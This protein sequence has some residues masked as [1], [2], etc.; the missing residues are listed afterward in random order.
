MPK[1]LQCFADED[2]LLCDAHLAADQGSCSEAGLQGPQ[3]AA[4][5]CLLPSLRAALVLAQRSASYPAAVQQAAEDV[6]EH[7]R[8]CQAPPSWPA[9][10][11]PVG[12]EL[13]TYKAYV[14][15]PLHDRQQLQLRQSRAAAAADC[16]QAHPPESFCPAV[17]E[18]GQAPGE[19]SLAAAAAYMLPRHERHSR[20]AAGQRLDWTWRPPAQGHALLAACMAGCKQ[21]RTRPKRGACNACKLQEATLAALAPSLSTHSDCKQGSRCARWT[22]AGEGD[23]VAAS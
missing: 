20:W 16:V 12:K 21:E 9:R 17:S 15:A 18:A 19:A 8:W 6:R 14:L 5:A 7:T 4:A 10:R 11:P 2:R 22:A 3:C 23:R 1:S 13:L